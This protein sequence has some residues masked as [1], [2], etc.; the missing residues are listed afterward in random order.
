L[1]QIFKGKQQMK[2]PHHELMIKK[3]GLVR[4]VVSMQTLKKQFEEFVSSK[5][6]VE[7]STRL[8]DNSLQVD[9]DN[10]YVT[11]KST[12][13]REFIDSIS[14]QYALVPKDATGEMFE[15]FN[16]T[17]CYERVWC[18]PLNEQKCFNVAYKAMLNNKGEC[19]V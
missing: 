4:E 10:T 7:Q 16:E 13:L 6:L 3:A 11:F 14:E 8:A 5:G 12:D 15:I 18:V 19:D 2:K 17:L 9:E 1:H